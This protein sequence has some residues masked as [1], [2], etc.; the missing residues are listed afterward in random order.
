MLDH[1]SCI[2]SDFSNQNRNEKAAKIFIK[3]I[4]FLKLDVFKKYLEIISRRFGFAW[5]INPRPHYLPESFSLRAD[6]GWRLILR[7]ITKTP[8]D[9]LFITYSNSLF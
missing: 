1:Y 4:L 8:W 7:V 2:L 6:N 9:N 3:Y 5:S